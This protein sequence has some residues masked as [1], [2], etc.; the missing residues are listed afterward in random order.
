M[1]DAECSYIAAIEGGYK[2]SSI[3]FLHELAQALN[4]SLKELNDINIKWL[5]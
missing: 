2:S 3:Y 5:V 4:T 1:I